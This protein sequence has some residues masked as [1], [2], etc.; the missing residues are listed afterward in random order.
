SGIKDDRNTSKQ[1]LNIEFWSSPLNYKGYKMSKYKLVLYGIASAEGL[2]LFK[3]DDD[4]Y[5]KSAS[6]VYHLDAF[7]DFK[8]YE[9]ITDE[10]IIN[11]LK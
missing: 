1:F 6:F 2:K 3:L 11:K 7:G 4:I 5:M 10:S 8:P 9:R